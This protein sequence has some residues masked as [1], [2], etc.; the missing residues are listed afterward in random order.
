MGRSK[1]GRPWGMGMK[2][3]LE[4]DLTSNLDAASSQSLPRKH[5]KKLTIISG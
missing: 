5:N 2:E 3:D 4:S 1:P